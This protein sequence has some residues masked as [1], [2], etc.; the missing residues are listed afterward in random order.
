MKDSLNQQL[1]N[2]GEGVPEIGVR[3]TALI[4]IGFVIMTLA[5][6]VYFKMKEA[7]KCIGL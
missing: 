1:Q 5:V 4:V 6:L 7:D 3:I 2:I